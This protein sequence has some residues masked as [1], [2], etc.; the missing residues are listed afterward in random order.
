M[1]PLTKSPSELVRSRYSCRTF[2]T[3]PLLTQDIGALSELF[4]PLQTG[5]LGTPIRYQLIAAREDETEELRG[6]GTYGFLKDPTAF[7]LGAVQDA[8]GALEDFGFQMEILVLK[9]TELGIGS[10]WLGGTFTKSRFVRMMDLGDGYY[11]PSIIALGYPA[12]SK[13]WFE[14]LTR[15]YAGADRRY[16][17]DK[18]F[19]Q[20]GFNQPLLPSEAGP[21]QEPLE[22]VRLAPSASNKQPWRIVHLG[23]YWHF[24]LQRTKN[25]PPPVFDLLLGLA[26]LQR[27]DL[28]IAM[29]HFAL[30]AQER[31]LAGS[32]QRSDP[33]LHQPDPRLEYNISWKAEL[34]Q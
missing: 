31:G 25:Y 12:D 30:S 15:S 8:T 13:G 7:I 28:G 29:A 14:R 34:Q 17:W 24:Y 4:Q 3:R 21:Y 33:D 6:L 1:M 18:L 23:P 9:A 10:C 26:D 5:P 19:F 20:D 11:I 32:W 2:Q 16:P 22:L 27:I